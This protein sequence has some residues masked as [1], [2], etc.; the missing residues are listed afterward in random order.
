MALFRLA[1]GPRSR[2]AFITHR[3]QSSLN[4]K[5]LG[6]FT[7]AS[8]S[9]QAR[10]DTADTSHDTSCCWRNSPA[11]SKNTFTSGRQNMLLTLRADSHG[12]SWDQHRSLS[13][14]Q[15]Q[16]GLGQRKGNCVSSLCWRNHHVVFHISFRSSCLSKLLHC[17]RMR[18]EL[19]L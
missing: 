7:H 17:V 13:S 5:S 18:C 6:G 1:W 19:F 8:H 4:L 10:K 15:K 3:S 14:S 9:S 16:H 2:N 12:I 11:A